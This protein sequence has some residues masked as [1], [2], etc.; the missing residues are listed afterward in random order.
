MGSRV[1]G[2]RVYGV[3]VRDSRL[4][5]GQA[6]SAARP[7]RA[8][9]PSRSHSSASPPRAAPGEF[10]FKAHRRLHYS[11]LDS[12]EMKRKKQALVHGCSKNKPTKGGTRGGLGGWETEELGVWVEGFPI[13]G[14]EAT[15]VHGPA[16]G[17]E[18]PRP[19]LGGICVRL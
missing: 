19:T 15:C 18:A 3:G 6:P 8:A 17:T 13:P 7:A 9:P 4:R 1:M 11:T 2:I 14:L 10:V 12:R 5:W 16:Q